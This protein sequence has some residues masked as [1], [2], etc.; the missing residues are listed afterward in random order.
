LVQIRRVGVALRQDLFARR[1]RGGELH[2]V[3][4]EQL[5]ERDDV[6]TLS[7]KLRDES[8]HRLDGL[9]AVAASVVQDDDAAL[10]RSD[11]AITR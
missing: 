6:V 11:A 7:A 9:R 10:V 1:Q 3:H 8:L 2:P 5:V 4:A